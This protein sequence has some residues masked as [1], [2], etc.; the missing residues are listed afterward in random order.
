MLGARRRHPPR[1]WQQARLVSL[2]SEGTQEARPGIP[3]AGSNGH[4]CNSDPHRDAQL[5]AGRVVCF[6][7]GRC[8]RCRSLLPSA[9]VIT[10]WTPAAGFTVS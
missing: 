4:S 5:G 10:P 2:S 3:A 1:R 6:K 9:R 7:W 8:R